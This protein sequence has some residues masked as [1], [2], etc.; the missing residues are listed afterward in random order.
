VRNEYEASENSSQ[1]VLSKRI[2]A[3]AFEWHNY[4][5]SR[6]TPGLLD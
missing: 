2:M 6:W 5:K 4:G 3:A 1:A